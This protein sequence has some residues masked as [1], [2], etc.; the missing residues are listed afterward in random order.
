MAVAVLAVFEFPAASVNFVP[1][2]ETDPEPV[3]VLDVGMK[4]TV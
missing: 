3:A 2:T 1:E 4:M